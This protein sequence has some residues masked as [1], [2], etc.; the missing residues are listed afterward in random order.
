MG[1]Q[2][3]AVAQDLRLHRRRFRQIGKGTV[4]HATEP[5]Q[6]GMLQIQVVQRPGAEH[7]QATDLRRQRGQRLAQQGLVV[8]PGADDDLLAVEHPSRAVQAA[9]LD[10]AYQGGKVKLD[11]QLATQVVNQAGQRFTRVHLLVIEAMQGRPMMA[12][13]AII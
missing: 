9:G 3:R 11:P 7:L 1:M 4:V 8:M 6:H 12:E 13:A 2:V 5:R 10:I